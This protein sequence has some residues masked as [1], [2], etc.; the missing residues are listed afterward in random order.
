MLSL[1]QK[2]NLLR[3]ECSKASD[4][5][6]EKAIVKLPET[7][8]E[9]VR[10]CF[11][12][13]K[14]KS[15]KGNRYNLNWIYEC[16]LIKIKSSKLYEHLR[17]K[18]ILPLPCVDTLQKYLKNV[19]SQFGFQKATFELLSKKASVMLPEDKRGLKIYYYRTEYYKIYE[20]CHLFTGTILLDEMKLRESVNFNNSTLEINGFTNLGDYTPEHQKAKKGD[21]ALVIMF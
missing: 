6:I 2:V 10:S 4:V 15:P 11:A 19:S 14:V 12:A 3:Q 8:K 16:I 13:S 5:A 20:K 17:T 9:A 18:Q 1:K 7:Q 21:H